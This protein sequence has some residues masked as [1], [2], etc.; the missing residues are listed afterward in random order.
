[1]K[2]QIL[3]SAK[4]EKNISVCRL[5]KILPCMLSGIDYYVN[6]SIQIFNVAGQQGGYYVTKSRLFILHVRQCYVM[7]I[8]AC[9]GIYCYANF[10]SF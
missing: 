6:Q 4:N 9:R 5:L 3:F 7:K 1:M 2:C 10:K 8:G